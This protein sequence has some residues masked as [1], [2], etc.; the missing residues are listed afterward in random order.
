MST[1]TCKSCGFQYDGTGLQAGVQFQ[2]TQCGSMVQVGA[3]ARRAGP[4]AVGPRAAGPRPAG[5]PP[6][7]M[8]AGATAGYG[9][10]PRKSNSAGVAIAISVSVLVVLVVV[11]GIVMGLSSSKERVDQSQQAAAEQRERERA[12]LAELDA[13]R[14]RSNEEIGTPINASRAK[15]PDVETAMRNNSRDA[16]D[17]L[18]DWGLYATY[19]QQ[20]INSNSAHLNSPIMAEGTWEKGEDGRYT[21]RWIGSAAR[22]QQSL[23]DRVLGY[24]E[25]YLFHAPAVRWVREKSEPTVPT[26]QFKISI[27]GVEYLGVKIFIEVQGGGSD[28]EFWV[29][30]PRGSTN[31]RVVNFIDGGA[32]KK[33]QEHEAA[34]PR[35]AEDNRESIYREGHDPTGRGALGGTGRP[36]VDDEGKRRDP[37]ANLPAV[38]KTGAT[39]TRPA[40]INCVSALGRGEKLNTMRLDQIRTESSTAEK[41]ATMG[42][43]IDLLI[44]AQASNNRTAKLNISTALYDVWKSFA[45]AD[46]SRED[47]VYVIDFNNQSET[48]L[49]V[50]RWIETYNEYKVD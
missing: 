11:I 13:E 30:A 4:R 39:P 6:G 7:R 22:N 2:C 12:R 49:I 16:V 31:A 26:S 17:S 5:G 19:N 36:D 29:G 28:K 27:N 33:L 32:T 37:A 43:F 23:R 48:D 14:K 20:L 3:P 21:G 50:R 42:A 47:L 45:Y 34:N 40:L 15:G 10:P 35:V 44:D 18:F 41:K 24:I 46:Y 38:A 8:P 25:E 9:P 1:I